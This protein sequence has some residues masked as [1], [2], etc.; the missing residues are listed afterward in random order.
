MMSI[1]P[2]LNYLAVVVLMMAGL[3]IVF[4][5][6]NLIKRMIGLV[7]FQSATGLFYISV[8][9]VSGGTAP[10]RIDAAGTEGQALAGR[11]DPAYVAQHGVEGVVYSNPLPQ[12]LILT[13]IVVTVATLAVGLSIAVRIREAYGTVEADDVAAQDRDAQDRN[14]PGTQP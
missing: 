14:Q 9:K 3:Y 4:S 10:I 1:L 8:G 7:V 6:G 2:H 11:L 12:V 5:S 13:A